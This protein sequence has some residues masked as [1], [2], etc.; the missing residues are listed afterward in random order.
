MNKAQIKESLWTH[1]DETLLSMYEWIVNDPK[2]RDNN[3][4]FTDMISDIIADRK[5]K[6]NK[7]LDN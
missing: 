3:E 2:M 6:T 7:I 4:D 1:D 5:E